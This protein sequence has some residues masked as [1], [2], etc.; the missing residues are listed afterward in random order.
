[1]RKEILLRI[2]T[3]DAYSLPL[4]ALTGNRGGILAPWQVAGMDGIDT[5]HVATAAGPFIVPVG[6]AMQKRW[7]ESN[8]T[9]IQHV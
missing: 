7:V 5:V 8:H 3:Y 2:D 4:T 9:N 1:M 6:R